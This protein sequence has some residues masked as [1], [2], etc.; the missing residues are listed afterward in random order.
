MHETF[1]MLGAE[2]EADLERHAA[3]WRRAKTL[4]NESQQITQGK[5]TTRP[6]Q[7]ARRG[8][9]SLLVPRFRL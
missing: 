5:R 4:L 3:K 2:H 1:R 7:M 8:L 9:F 6:R